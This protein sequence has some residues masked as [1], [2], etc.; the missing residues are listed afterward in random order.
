MDW[1]AVLGQARTPP[2]DERALTKGHW[3]VQALGEDD[4]PTQV[5][6]LLALADTQPHEGV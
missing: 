4:D 6:A 5:Q 1:E 3:G 2:C